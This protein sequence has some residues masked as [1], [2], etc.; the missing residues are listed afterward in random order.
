M[1]TYICVYV[2]VRLR[3]NKR[4]RKERRSGFYVRR[5]LFC[6]FSFCFCH[7]HHHSTNGVFLFTFF[8]R[9][10]IERLNRGIWDHKLLWLYCL[11]FEVCAQLAIVISLP[12]ISLCFRQMIFYQFKLKFV[13]IDVLERAKY[14]IPFAYSLSS[15]YLWAPWNPKFLLRQYCQ[16]FTQMLSH[17]S[18]MDEWFMD[19]FKWK[20][21]SIAYDDFFYHMTLKT[22]LQFVICR[23]NSMQCCEIEK[24]ESHNRWIM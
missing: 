24:T 12:F 5:V 3:L 6:C 16:Y 1:H 7:R 20:R 17:V 10:S 21:A 19:F 13:R 18:L 4:H 11:A 22:G 9:Y 23:L 8:P 15:F 14:I 2:C